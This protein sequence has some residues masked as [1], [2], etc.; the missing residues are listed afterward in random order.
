MSLRS[1]PSMSAPML[2]RF[3]SSLLKASV[4]ALAVV[5]AF[6]FAA[7]FARAERLKNLATFQGVRDNPLV[8]YGLVVGLDNTG[9]QTM[10][11]PFTTQSLTNMLS[12]L[13]ITLPAGKNMQL[14]NVA[15]VMVTATLPAFAQPGSQ[16][17]IVVSSMGNAKSLRGGTLL[18]TPLKGAD[19]Q[20]YAIAQ[21]NM[22]VGG[23]GA[24]ANGSKVQVN[25]L[26]VGRIANGAIVERA[27]AA[28][29]PDGGIINLELKDTDFGTA[30]RVV[31]AINR[32][33]GG[34]VAAALDGRVVQ[35]RAPASPAARVGFLARIE[36]IDVTPAKAA[37]KVI[38]NA[39]TGSIVM[40][41][42]VTVED[43]AVAHGNLSVVINT[44]PVISQPAPFSNGQTVVA[45]VSQIDM[46]QQGG[47]LQ[48][49]KAGASLAAVVK[50]L[51]ALGATPA[52][53]QTILE[54]MRAAGALRAELEII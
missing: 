11:T 32:S 30:E 38:L 49:V 15:A 21:G 43:C 5:V 1:D 3:L 22:L 26:A 23:A 6:G 41:Q 34:G 24:S 8:G 40:N 10:Q 45:P 13:G 54:A 50:G 28:F 16:L 7:N 2:A 33:M 9:D 47:S 27:V 51:N 48:I 17:D 35:V 12:Q 14:K 39:R 4:T 53:L 31:E 42:A 52:D 44:Q 18:M 37:A 46:K 20:V 36:S 29:Q 25:Q 19:G